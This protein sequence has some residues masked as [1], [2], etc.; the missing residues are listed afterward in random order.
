MMVV[1]CHRPLVGC[2][3]FLQPLDGCLDGY[4]YFLEAVGHNGCQEIVCT[5]LP[6]PPPTPPLWFGCAMVGA[7][8]W[9]AEWCGKALALWLLSVLGVPLTFVR[10]YLADNT[11]ATFGEDGGRA[12]HCP[13]VDVLRL[14]YAA[15]LLKS[16]AVEI[17]VPPQHNSGSH[18]Q[19]R[20]CRR[21]LMLGPNRACS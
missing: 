19:W 20:W 1:I 18:R 11:G 5:K 13:W 2:C 6:P 17:Y 14:C 4:S 21:S 7:S 12:S 8:S 3:Y 9:V 16:R 15:A 10:S